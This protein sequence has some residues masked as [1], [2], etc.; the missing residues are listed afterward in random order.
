MYSVSHFQGHDMPADTEL[1]EDYQGEIKEII[2][3][4]FIDEGML[5]AYAYALDGA[6][7]EDIELE[8][9]TYLTASE[10]TALQTIEQN[11]PESFWE[12]VTV[13]TLTEALKQPTNERRAA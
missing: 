6:T 10:I 11:A 13:Q 8:V 3:Q 1:F 4:S 2:L 12:S 5:G 9:A 7:D